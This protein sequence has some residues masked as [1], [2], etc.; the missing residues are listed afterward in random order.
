MSDA[1]VTEKDRAEQFA[2]KILEAANSRKQGTQKMITQELGAVVLSDLQAKWKAANTNADREYI[3]RIS[4]EASDG[5]AEH[6]KDFD[7]PCLCDLC[8]SYGDY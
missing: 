7:L 1:T 6:P 3:E 2:A 8:K 4:L 5:V